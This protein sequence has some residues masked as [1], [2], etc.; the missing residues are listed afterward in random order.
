MRVAR[1]QRR[2]AFV[3]VELATQASV[4]G[5]RA[6]ALVA[7]ISVDARAVMEA[8]LRRAL[9]NH[10]HLCLTVVARVARASAVALVAAIE[11]RAVAAKVA[12]VVEFHALVDVNVAALSRVAR[13]S[14]VAL[15]V[16][17]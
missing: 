13:A 10:V 11:V 16:S 15:I 1:E 3:E 7:F 6:L 8:R 14:A 9:V 12:A 2:R 4:A 17:H 5:A